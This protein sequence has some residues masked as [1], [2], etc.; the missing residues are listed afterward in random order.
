MSAEGMEIAVVGS[1]IAGL[2]AAWLL[3]RRH[4]VTLYE[5]DVPPGR[6]QQYGRCRRAS[7]VDT[8]F[9]VYNEATYPNL[10]AL[11]AHLGVRDQSLGN[12]LRRIDGWW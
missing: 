4:R 8:G 12:E 7:P 1:G 11:F 2:S 3:S 5:S 10:T 6:P 9:I